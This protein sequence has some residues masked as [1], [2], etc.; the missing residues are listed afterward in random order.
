MVLAETPWFVLFLLLNSNNVKIIIN[1]ISV[2][3]QSSLRC[4]QPV[5]RFFL[6]LR[7]KPSCLIYLTFCFLSFNSQWGML[8]S[9][10][11]GSFFGIWQ[12]FFFFIFFFY[13]LLLEVLYTCW[14]AA[15][16]LSVIVQLLL[17]FNSYYNKYHFPY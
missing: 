5:S 4:C 1:N 2:L 3:T 8:V 17:I 6:V 13:I 9:V 14:L 11:C 7:R 16:M 15:S 12:V 10:Y